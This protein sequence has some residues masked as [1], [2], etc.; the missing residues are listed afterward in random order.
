MRQHEGKVARHGGLQGR[1]GR[2]FLQP[3]RVGAPA[4]QQVAEPL[5]HDAAAGQH[6][7][8]LGDVA[9]VLN[10]LVE[11]LRKAR[12]DQHREVGVFGPALFLG[13]GVP[14]HHGDAAVPGV[15]MLL[16]DQPA[17]VHAE[18]AH[19]VF[20]RVGVI[21]QL[22]LVQVLG[23]RVQHGVRH[24]DADADVHLVVGDGQVVL[25]CDAAEPAGPPAA[26]GE[27]HAGRL[28]RFLLP[29]RAGEQHAAGGP[30]AGEDPL[31]GGLLA[32]LEIRARRKV[33]VHGLEHLIG[34]FRP[35]VPHRAGNQL[36]IFPPGPVG[37]LFRELFVFAVNFIRRAEMQIDSIHIMNQA[38]RLPD[39][40][41]VGDV[42]ADLFRK[43][44]LSVRK[45]T[46]A[47]PAVHNAAGGAVGAD[48][49]GARGARPAL[50]GA[51]GIHN[52]KLLFRR[53]LIQ[54]QRG[55]N[56]GRAGA[57]YHDIVLSHIGLPASENKDPLENALP[58][59]ARGAR[60][61]SRP[62]PRRQSLLS[63]H[64]SRRK[65]RRPKTRRSV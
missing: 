33:L 26:G 44:K 2:R 49:R 17:R 65:L 16:A 19:L 14:V 29:V 54:L 53:Q 55:E 15:V 9:A 46:R 56:A 58:R 13:V 52:Q 37:D 34:I 60:A 35:H 32:E 48:A 28:H 1:D 8:E 3:R 25:F 45:R 21:D 42:A 20:K 22:R 63:Y 30:A 12:G 51:A 41:V 43:R 11:R 5:N 39:G 47:G 61:A 27:D 62:A 6:V 24:L 64:I 59:P 40:H 57:Y 10:R 18:G 38:A 7:A 23:Q 36:D 50:D 4:H 31:R